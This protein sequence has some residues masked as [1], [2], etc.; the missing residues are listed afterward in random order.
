MNTNRPSH[1]SIRSDR[2]DTSDLLRCQHGGEARRS[3][4]WLLTVPPCRTSRPRV[5]QAKKR[6]SGSEH[7]TPPLQRDKPDTLHT[8]RGRN[9]TNLLARTQEVRQ[10]RPFIPLPNDSTGYRYPLYAS[11]PHLTC[12]TTLA[13]A[14]NTSH[15]YAQK[16]HHVPTHLLILV[17]RAPRFGV[18]P[19]P[20]QRIPRHRRVVRGGQQKQHP[21]RL[22][23]QLLRQ[24]VFSQER[25]RRV[26]GWRARHGRCTARVLRC[27]WG[28]LPVTG[29]LC[30]PRSS[31][32]TK[33][34]LWREGEGHWDLETPPTH[35]NR[36]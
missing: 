22:V 16:R 12:L 24:P 2:R 26:R 28:A 19:R 33:L 15:T 8:T 25:P 14:Q 23:L 27:S 32:P 4:P 21:R 10:V 9:S 5:Y 35:E 36:Q 18:V 20:A 17:L 30:V 6:L 31:G 3:R 11:Q 1:P 13:N 7:G 29:L 34:K